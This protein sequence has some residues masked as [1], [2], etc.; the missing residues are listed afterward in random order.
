MSKVLIIDD[1][2]SI[3]KLIREGTKCFPEVDDITFLY[4]LSGRD[5]VDLFREQSPELV[6]LDMHMPVMDGLAVTKNIMS[7]DPS[8]NIFIMTAYP[9]EP[10]TMRTIECGARGFL[11]KSGNYIVEVVAIISAMTNILNRRQ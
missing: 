7:I 1:D 8:A 9:S 3:L 5:G 4:A 11:S 10:Q 6:I 2:I